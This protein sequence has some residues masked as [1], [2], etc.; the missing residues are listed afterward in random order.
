M[1]EEMWRSLIEGE[2]Y[3]DKLLEAFG[4]QVETSEQ[5]IMGNYILVQGPVTATALLDRLE[6]G[7]TFEDLVQEIQAD[8]SAVPPART[9]LFDWSSLETIR[10]RFGEEFANVAFN[11][12]AGDYARLPIPLADD[13]FYLAFVEGNEVRELS[14]FQ[15][16]Q[17]RSEL[18]Q[19][20]LDEQKLGE[21]IVYGAWRPY[22]PREPSLQ[23][24]LAQ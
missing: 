11:T 3:R 2:L 6:A 4:D 17:K 1:S 20:W 15:I 19:A 23:D 22:I 7:E 12:A 16:E 10:Q 18:F 5:Q 24:A 8:E 21:G 14:D 13:Q 9:G